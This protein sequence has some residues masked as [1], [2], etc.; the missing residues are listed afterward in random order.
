[1]CEARAQVVSVGGR[2]ITVRVTRKSIQSSVT[3]SLGIRL[4]PG[5]LDIEDDRDNENRTIR[6]MHATGVAI[7]IHRSETR[8]RD[9]S[10]PNVAASSLRPTLESLCGAAWSG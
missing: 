1:M 8:R 10:R 9:R 2:D 7:V 4:P 3:D 5:I 6:L